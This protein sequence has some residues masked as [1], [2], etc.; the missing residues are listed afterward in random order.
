MKRLTPIIFCVLPILYGQAQ[1]TLGLEECYELGEHNYPLIEREELIARSKTYSVDNALKA[2]LPQL[3]IGGQASYQSDVTE[4]PIRMP[5]VEIETLSKDQYKVY[6][7]LSQTLYN[8]GIARYQKEAEEAAAVIEAQKLKVD[9]YQVRSRINAL[10]FGVLLIQEQIRQSD[11]LKKD[12]TSGI[13]QAEASISQGAALKGAADVLHAELLRVEQRIIEL[14][15]TQE[16][17]K[18]MLAL[19]IG[20]E[21]GDDVIFQ[22]PRPQTMPGE[23]DRPELNLYRYQKATLDINRSLLNARKQPRLDLFF[24]GGYGR[25]GLNMLKNEFDV[26]YIGGVRFSWQLSRFYTLKNEKELLV[27]KQRSIDVQRETFLFNTNL[28]LHQHRQAI[29]KLQRLITTDQEIITLRTRIKETAHAQLAH[30]TITSN[31]YIREVNAEDQARLSL[32]LHEIQLLQ[33]HYEYQ[34]TAGH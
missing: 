33:T 8:G 32:S 7:E 9:L 24:Q 12:I 23:I 15:S 3:I 16:A 5:G 31:D 10:F 26:Y 17:Y 20:R 34:F 27:L 29:E 4:V 1:H 28:A 13:K 22:R 25:P 18:Q 19:F 14:Q 2:H 11:V 21:I 6:G 30:G